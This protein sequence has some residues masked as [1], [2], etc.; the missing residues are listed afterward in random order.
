M[1]NVDI[2]I[3]MNNFVGFFKKNPDQLKI[4]IGEINPE[5]FYSEIKSIAEK[6][7][8]DEKEIVPTRK[9]MVDLLV[10]MNTNKNK[11]QIT[12]VVIPFMEHR[13]GKIIM[14]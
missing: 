6:N 13:M 11:K 7:L 2:D 4:L 3:Y 1:G 14:N 12:D 9:Q 5:S 10:G 8:L